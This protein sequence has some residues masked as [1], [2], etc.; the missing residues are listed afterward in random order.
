MKR[1]GPFDDS[2]TK[3]SARSLRRGKHPTSPILQE[4]E[5]RRMKWNP[6]E[7]S[8]TRWLRRTG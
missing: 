6:P 1:H 7:P 8:R 3:L 5:I 4:H 2:A